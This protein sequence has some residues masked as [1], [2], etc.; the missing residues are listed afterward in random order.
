M[1]VDN[2]T[3]VSAYYPIQPSKYSIGQYRAWIQNFC[4]IPSTMVIFTDEVYALEIYQWR[5]MY[6][7]RTKVIIRSFDSFAMTCP[8][9][10]LFW[11]KQVSQ[12]PDAKAASAELYAVWSLKQE[13]VRIAIH[14]NFFLSKWFVWCDIGIQRYS[15]LQ[16]FYMNFP[17]DIE[18]LCAK[19]R[20]NFLEIRRIPQIYLD[21]WNESKP[22]V[23]P[24][25]R[26][27]IG[28]GC[29][30]GDI[31]A[32]T[33]FGEAYKDMLKEFALRGWFAGSET[34]IFFTILMEKKTKPFRLFH[35]RE[36]GTP[37]ITG[38]EW[39]SFPVMLGGMIDAPLDTRFELDL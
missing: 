2:V 3:I 28:G 10:M 30:V 32:W 9:M 13:F 27:I 15:A 12:D 17:S 33:D 20:M 11:D 25:P 16:E 31:D 5:K 38:I 18:R 24:F 4:K 21:D 39:M 8:S 35:A 34:D 19:G 22:M 14:N 23:H 1:K 6:L 29:I 37:V 26:N 7:D 36:F